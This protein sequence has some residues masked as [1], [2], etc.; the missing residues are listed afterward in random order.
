MQQHGL[1]LHELIHSPQHNRILRLAY[2]N[3]DGP[4]EQ[5]LVNRLDAVESISR[6]FEFTIE[7]LCISDKVR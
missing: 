6:D 1:A 2:P 7:L 4:R 5:F 3:S